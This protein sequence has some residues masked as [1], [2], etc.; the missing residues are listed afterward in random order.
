M[1][2]NNNII[3]TIFSDMNPG[4]FGHA[5]NVSLRCSVLNGESVDVPEDIVVVRSLRYPRSATATPRKPFAV[6]RILLICIAVGVFRRAHV[7]MGPNS[8][9]PRGRPSLL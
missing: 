3:K 8:Q 4:F 1:D 7:I 9:I 5:A 2:V 6:W